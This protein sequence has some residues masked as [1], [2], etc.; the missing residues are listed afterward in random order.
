MPKTRDSHEITRVAKSVEE[1]SVARALQMMGCEKVSS[2][3]G[4]QLLDYTLARIILS[5]DAQHGD[6]PGG[7][8]LLLLDP[9]VFKNL[10]KTNPL[11]CG[12]LPF[13]FVVVN[14]PDPF[15]M[16]VQSMQLY[17]DIQASDQ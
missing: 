3:V 12:T 4:S 5:R 8:N 15:C 10:N 11:F 13:S 9:F 7:D 14:I 1:L 17:A 6:Y 16:P 2:L